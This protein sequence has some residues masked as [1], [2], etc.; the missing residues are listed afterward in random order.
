MD[1]FHKVS[2]VDRHQSCGVEHTNRMILEHA[3]ALVQTERAAEFWDVPE[4]VQTVENI[5]NR[6]SDWE[7]GL[8]PNE[9]T[10]GSESMVYYTLL[11]PMKTL[12][13]KHEYLRKL[14]EYLVVARQE[15]ELF[16][17]SILEKRAKDNVDE[18]QVMEYQPG[19]LILF[20]PNPR[21][22]IHKLVPT[23]LGPYRVKSQERGEIYCHQVAT[24]VA[25]QFHVTRVYPFTGT[26]EE[27]FQLACRDSNQYGVKA[28]LGYRGDAV[29]ARRYMTFLVEFVDGDK[30][31]IQYGPDI[32]SN[33]VYQDYIDS[34]PELAILKYTALEAG[35]YISYTRKLAIT[36]KIAPVVFYIDMRTLGFTW[37]DKLD[38]PQA[39]TS[40]YLI[41]AQFIRHTN[42]QKT[43]AEVF[44]PVLDEKL[45]NLDYSWFE[46][47]ATR[48]QIPDGAILVD[49]RFLVQ[50]PQILGAQNKARQRELERLYSPVIA[51]TPANRRGVYRFKDTDL[52]QSKPT[53]IMKPRSNRRIQVDDHVPD[54][55]DGNE[56]DHSRRSRIGPTRDTEEVLLDS[57]SSPRTLVA[58]V[59][60]RRYSRDIQEVNTGARMNLRKL[61]KN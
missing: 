20:K 24:G 39:D 33:A 44:L 7:T 31:W 27:A 41:G 29:A 55:R 17:K 8:S 57:T 4:Y 38:L 22:K 12:E 10:Y 45:T 35:R 50:Y 42:K 13:D 34:I 9:L 49:E 6:Y 40:L 58:P 21:S 51:G 46:L 37:Y 5:L 28:I 36:S 56:S 52:E 15:S 59:T 47:N 43:R 19:D 53:L 61:N 26:E 23:T 11:D 2:L 54:I 30:S 60:S 1:M 25:R 14:N 16:H 32:T 3:K 18:D 48:I